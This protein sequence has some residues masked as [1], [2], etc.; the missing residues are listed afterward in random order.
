MFVLCFTTSRIW[1]LAVVRNIRFPLIPAED[2]LRKVKPAGVVP[3]DILLEALEY[4]AAPEL[5]DPTNP[6]FR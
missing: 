5:A 3:V 4:H 1:Y 2:L 6:R